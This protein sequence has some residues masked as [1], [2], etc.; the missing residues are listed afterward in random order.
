V[1]DRYAD[2]F[3]EAGVK[4]RGITVA[5]AGYYGA[6]RLLRGSEPQAFLLLDQHNSTFELYGESPARRFFSA[7]FDSRRMA[8]EKAV[9]AAAA[10]LRLE[11]TDAAGDRRA[12]PLVVCGDRTVESTLPPEQ[13]LGSPFQAPEEFD[14]ARDATAFATALAGACPR[15]G[16][17]T[18]LLP[19]ARRS[20]SARWPMALTALT[21][22]AGAAGALLLWLRGPM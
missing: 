20:S 16:W 21:A 14:L 17:R 8:L 18:N 5:A 11:E 10:E 2:L 9:T 22:V 15:W 1:V 13:I 19:P 7:T 3:S 4:L 12:V 6:P